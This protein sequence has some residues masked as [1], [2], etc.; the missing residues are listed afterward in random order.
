[1]KEAIKTDLNGFYVEPVIVPLSQ[2]G[3]TEILEIAPSEMEEALTGYIV[4]EKV[5]EGLFTPRWD[6]SNSTWIEGMEQEQI[7]E[8]RNAPRPLSPE[9]RIAQLEAESVEVMLGLTEIYE[10]LAETNAAPRLQKLMSVF[11]SAKR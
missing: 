1:M 4:A 7:D 9:D 5:P 10:A 2:T 11:S 8:I 3:V 6:F